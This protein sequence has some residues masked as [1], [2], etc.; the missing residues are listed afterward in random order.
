LPVGLGTTNEDGSVLV[1]DGSNGAVFTYDFRTLEPLQELATNCLD[2]FP[3]TLLAYAG[4]EGGVGTLYAES[5]SLC[6]TEPREFS[7]FEDAESL[8]PYFELNTRDATFDACALE[9]LRVANALRASDLT[10][11]DCSARQPPIKDLAFLADSLPSLT[12]L[13]ISG[14]QVV[15]LAPLVESPPFEAPT[16]RLI[17]FTARDSLSTVDLDQVVEDITTLQRLDVTG[18]RGA[19]CDDLNAGAA[20]G[21]DVSADQCVEATLRGISGFLTTPRITAEKDRVFIGTENGVGSEIFEFSL[22]DLEELSVI[23]IEPVPGESSFADDVQEIFLSEDDR[24]LISVMRNGDLIFFDLE[25]PDRRRLVVNIDDL[26]GGTAARFLELSP[27]RFAVLNNENL[28]ELIIEDAEPVS[29]RTV[30]GGEMIDAVQFAL[31][32]DKSTLV[33]ASTTA[34]WKVDATDPDLPVIARGEREGFATD[35]ILIHPDGTRFFFGDGEYDLETFR[36]IRQ[37]SRTPVAFSEDGSQTVY[38]QF[39]RPFFL[40][41]DTA[42]GEPVDLIRFCNQ[43]LAEPPEPFGEFWLSKTFSALCAQRHVPYTP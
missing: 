2:F 29:V 11:L 5:Q 3:P 35:P 21:I 15:T 17:D 41:E 34:F 18:S 31:T 30:A 25:D 14:S 43:D 12:Q 40:V 33:L 7:S 38:E 10:S 28:L 27:N 6:I 19:F 9:A 36:L 8:D 23:D 20:R 22:P 26:V 32:S 4:R 13:D 39:T 37:L 42:T 16:L 1:V 24:T